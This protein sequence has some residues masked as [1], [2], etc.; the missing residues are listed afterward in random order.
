MIHYIIYSKNRA[1]QLDLL[2]QSIDQ[3]ANLI[4]ASIIYTATSDN[5]WSGYQHI[6]TKYQYGCVREIQKQKVFKQDAIDILH[7]SD[8][9]LIGFLTDDTVFYRYMPFYTD[10]Y[11]YQM[12]ENE[13][14]TFSLRNGYNTQHQCHFERKWLELKPHW[15]KS[16]L[17]MWDTSQYDYGTDFGR[18]IS[19]DGNF[20]MRDVFMPMLIQE[21]WNDPRSLDG[22][23][24][25]PLGKNMMAFKESVVVNIPVNLACNGYANNWGRLRV[26][27]L[28]DLNN[29]LLE[30]K[31]LSLEKMD[32]SNVWSSHL[33]LELFYA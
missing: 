12:K 23:N 9:P 6:F 18:P 13:C 14:N 7:E 26:Y 5:F 15:E 2:L 24:P 8:T 25:A 21:H 28:E 32:F 33:E 30:G 16:D 19:I 27:T 3:L 17:I 11:Y 22:L 4:T 10:F 20:F 1:A 29:A 31:R